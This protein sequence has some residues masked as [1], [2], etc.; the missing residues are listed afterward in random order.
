MAL[1]WFVL[2]ANDYEDFVEGMCNT[3]QLSSDILV[4]H[5]KCELLGGMI[6]F[7]WLFFFFF[8]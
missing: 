2:A 7:T 5:L 1:G 6:T 4:T 3:K 8:F